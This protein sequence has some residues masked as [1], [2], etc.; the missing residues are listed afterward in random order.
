MRQS[1]GAEIPNQV[2]AP[3]LSLGDRESGGGREAH[4]GTPSL[5]SPNIRPHLG[6]SGARKGSRLRK[7]V[8]ECGCP[9]SLGRGPRPR[10]RPL[11]DS[12]PPFPAACCRLG[13]SVSGAATI[14]QML[15]GQEAASS[16]GLFYRAG[17]GEPGRETDS[18]AGARFPHVET[19]PLRSLRYGAAGD[20]APCTQCVVYHDAGSRSPFCSWKN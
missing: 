10:T 3:R 6:G 17:F 4:L 8:G 20:R 14:L 1:R 12:S 7:Q 13:S 11:E 16:C 18:G 2:G 19:G 15:D 9:A 5:S